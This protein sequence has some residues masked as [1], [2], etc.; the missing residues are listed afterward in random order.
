MS[1]NNIIDVYCFGKEIGRIG[2]DENLN[3]SFFQYNKEFLKS[4]EYTNLFP[5]VFK[6]IPQI[7]V[8]S[9]FNNEVFRSMPPMVADSL[10]DAFGNII[11]KTWLESNKKSLKAIT[12]LEQLTYVG[13]RGMGALEYHPVKTIPKNTSINIEDI[14][15]VLKIV[16]DNKQETSATG[17]NSAALLN[18]FKIGSSAGGV[19]PKILISENK[20]TKAI[21]PGDIIFTNDYNHYLVKLNID[22]EA[23]YQRETIEYSYYLTATSIGITMMPSHMID[24]K[25]FA[26]LRFDRQ[27]GQKKH[28]L[29]A[30]GMTGWGPNDP[31]VS[32]Y[33]NLFELAVYLKLHYKD[34]DEIFRRMVFNV[35]FCNQDD[36]L[37]N[38]AFI[39]NETD[40]KWELSPA[41]DITYSLNPLLNFTKT[42]RA[43][44]I[45]NKRTN[46]QLEDVLKIADQYTIKNPKR[47]IEDTQNAIK[48]WEV[49]AKQLKIS[50]KVIKGMKDDFVIL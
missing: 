29:T 20:K 3:K 13:N 12:A 40:D 19:R 23:G 21:I 41:Y 47:I 9:Q 7:Q 6:R 2:L 48:A 42:A 22:D 11:F 44:S 18:V 33:E 34:I 4:G 50:A 27:E 26:T 45:N 1:K 38:H 14:V 39:Y 24:N 31:V 32:S 37:K 15:R 16:L 36:H 25:H 35:V 30:T 49:T 43:L 8:F 5:L 46:I 28:I 10:P 17:L